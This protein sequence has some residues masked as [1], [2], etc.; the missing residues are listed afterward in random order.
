MPR[1]RA[2][3]LGLSAGGGA[4]SVSGMRLDAPSAQ[5]RLPADARP[6]AGEGAWAGAA[7][8]M[9]VCV[10]GAAVFFLTGYAIDDTFIHLQFARNLAAGRGFRFW[11][12]DP[13]VYG[14]T[15]P[16][17][18]FVLASGQWLGAGG[19]ALARACSV[20]SGA[21]GLLLFYRVSCRS[22]TSRLAWLPV[23]LLAVNPWWVR[24]SASGMEASL[25]TAIVLAAWLLC[26]REGDRRARDMASA[27]MMCAVGVVARPELVLL[28]V[29]LLLALWRSK[30]LPSARAARWTA[31]AAIGAPGLLA[32]MAW[33]WFAWRHFGSPVPNAVSAKAA[34]T[35]WGASALDAVARLVQML[36]V[37]DALLVAALLVTVGRAV[38]GAALSRNRSPWRS[39]PF[40]RMF[41]VWWPLSV[42]A[43]LLA[44]R[45]PMQ[46]RYL[47]V[48]WPCLTLLGATAVLRFL[49]GIA[50]PVRRLALAVVV[51]CP[52]ATGAWIV[53]PHMRA[54]EANLAVYKEMASFIREQT[55]P[56]SL[57]AVHEIGVLGYEGQRRLLDLGGLV[58]PEVNRRPT[59]GQPEELTVSLDFLRRAGATHYLD[60]HGKV[61]A[62]MRDGKRS[63]AR[64]LELAS[65]RFVGGTSLTNRDTYTQRLYEID[66][67]QP[68]G[69]LSKTSVGFAQMFCELAPDKNHEA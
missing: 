18:V 21:I 69:P 68:V 33:G 20:M 44:G 1:S 31:C 12:G 14:C 7:V 57:I 55:P 54:V 19:L 46:S 30:A 16:A 62:L 52:V 35:G 45:G 56:D 65:W 25:G 41:A 13:P 50:T 40:T 53:Y 15:S 43:F 38:V 17:W 48:A 42:V 59:R 63:G 22:I 67:R 8:I 51:A 2:P 27:G 34:E 61:A 36:A 11:P 6:V 66:W 39:G 29:I 9:G 26:L 4:P 58:S 49:D 32:G 10:W 64:F 60:P 47:L 23:A 37:S 5:P 24:W 28:P 3:A